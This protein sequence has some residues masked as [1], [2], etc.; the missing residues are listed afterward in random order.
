M[1]R[2][3]DEHQEEIKKMA[4]YK[5]KVY[6]T[7]LD[8]NIKLINLQQ[9]KL[10]VFEFTDWSK[11]LDAKVEKERLNRQKLKR[12]VLTLENYTE[13]YIPLVVLRTVSDLLNPV[14]EKA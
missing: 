6:D 12:N 13:R 1:R 14:F 9:D 7:V 10:N 2:E 5:A 8:Q 3:I 4:E 11:K